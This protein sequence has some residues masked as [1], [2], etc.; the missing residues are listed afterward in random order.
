MLLL[1][2]VFLQWSLRPLLGTRT[3]FPFFLAAIGIAAMWLGWRP[4]LIVLV[5]GLINSMF[6]LDPAGFGVA[7]VG[8]R[9]SIALY[10]A[11]AVVL[12]VVGDK[13]HRSRFREQDLNSQVQDLQALQELGNRIA[14][15]PDLRGQLTAILRSLCELQSARH[16]L[17]S[18]CD[19]NSATLTAAA[20]LGFSPEAEIALSALPVGQGACGVAFLE[21][22]VVVVEDIE[23]DPNFAEF[24]ELG[25]QEGFRCIH[26][27]PMFNRAGEAFGVV[28]IYFPEPKERTPRDDQLG[29]LCSQ[30]ASVLIEHEALRQ[31]AL[32]LSRQVEV[33]LESSAVAFCLFK[34]LRDADGT[35]VD[36]RW[37]YMNSA[38]AHLLGHEVPELVGHAVRD[39]LPG[40]WDEPGVLSQYV[41]ALEKDATVEFEFRS[42]H[43]SEGWFHVIASPCEGGLAVW[44]TDVTERKFH[45]QT[46]READQRKDEFLA[47]LAHELRNP[48][49][50]IRQAAMI[51]RSP[52]AKPEQQRWSLEVIERQVGNMAV[53]LD[54]L[55]DVS[56]ITR[57]KLELRRMVSDLRQAADSALEAA[58][59]VIEARKQQLIIEWPDAPLWAMVDSIRIAQVISNLLTNASKYT[60]PRGTV[61]LTARREGNDA[62]IEVSDN[63]I[64][65]PRDSLE[66]VF[67]MFTQVRNPHSGGATGLGIGL[68]LSRGLAQMHGATLTAQSE[69]VGRGSTFTLRL[70]LCE[71]PA[72]AVSAKPTVNGAGRSRRVLV[73]DDNR[74]AA[75][76][77]AE[78]LRLEGHDVSL[79]FDGE[80]ALQ[81]FNE[82]APEVALLDIGM[83]RMSGNEVASAIRSSPGGES[84]LL[85]AITGWGQ[86]RDRAAAKKAGFDFH[87][88]KPVNPDHVLRL[89]EDPEAARLIE[90]A[91]G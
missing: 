16:G 19:T 29:D 63:G 3:P 33:A 79:A 23:Q 58:R 20:T 11:A 35:V 39:V 87:F 85:V 56:R 45:E 48:L 13:L 69:G 28:S 14:L 22:R 10:V 83:P 30:M 65:I 53:L 81:Q 32:A 90:D 17:V 6:W 8:D 26:S 7:N 44:F 50:P 43:P 76:S 66:R 12:L 72:H 77:L 60:H 89:I 71:A 84:T 55:L 59:P 9:V 67:E 74:D 61:R 31:N 64:G 40:A 57:G 24:R 49:A 2:A 68:A 34:P 27:R 1:L 91:H 78:V 88:T 80:A 47:T 73:A 41:M 38:A 46:L 82:Q 52:E 21:Q 62:V 70:D 75:E 5:G 86:E 15:L 18:L 51:A 4:A 36:L 42:T 37:D 25:R 54:D